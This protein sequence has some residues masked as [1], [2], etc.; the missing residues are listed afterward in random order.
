MTDRGSAEGSTLEA[1]I[2]ELP[3]DVQ[4][5][6]R[7][8]FSIASA[9]TEEKRQEAVQLLLHQVERAG[10]SLDTDVVAGATG[11][12]RRD[13]ARLIAALSTA[14]ALL[15]ETSASAA[16]FVSVGRT[17]IFAD[18]DIAAVTEI[19]NAIASQ[20]NELQKSIAHHRLAS[21]VLP[22]LTG[23]DVAVDLRFEFGG[24]DMKD[25]VAVA[26]VHIGTDERTQHL[27]L[28]LD[29]NDIERVIDK[30]QRT[31]KQMDMA[32][33]IPTPATKDVSK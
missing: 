26:V 28:Q 30:L 5:I 15:T 3:E 19:S 29:R 20:R 13:A 31:L 14:L 27:W 33:A 12:P 4:R 32:E 17:K 10:G 16:D 2:A 25:R 21:R 18:S 8:G 11:L 23:F 9:L 7:N 22:S 1:H 24:D 6:I